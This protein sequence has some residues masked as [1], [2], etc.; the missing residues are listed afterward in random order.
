[1]NSFQ[2]YKMR[3]EGRRARD[4]LELDGKIT[5]TMC[6]KSKNTV[7]HLLFVVI[8][9]I[10]KNVPYKNCTKRQIKDKKIPSRYVYRC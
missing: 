10:K 5:N 4:R 3:T 2:V 8:V 6:S 9:S 1:M 7:C